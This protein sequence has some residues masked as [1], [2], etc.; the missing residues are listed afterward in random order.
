MNR[1]VNVLNS[2]WTPL[3][4]I[5]LTISVI[6]IYILYPIVFN[7]FFLMGWHLHT[8]PSTVAD[9]LNAILLGGGLIATLRTFQKRFKAVASTIDSNNYLANLIIRLNPYWR[10]AMAF[11]IVFCVFYL[12]I[13]I[14]FESMI[15]KINNISDIVPTFLYGHIKELLVTGGFLGALK[16]YEKSSNLD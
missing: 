10:P 2:T 11:S 14:P 12:Y 5:V 3:L 1:T 4:G 16:I 13:L 7:V 6:F 15:V 9:N 8:I